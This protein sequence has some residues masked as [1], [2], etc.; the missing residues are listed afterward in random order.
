M[1][2]VRSI[3]DERGCRR[4]VFQ[5]TGRTVRLRVFATDEPLA[6]LLGQ[7]NRAY[8]VAFSPDGR[9]LAVQH[10]RVAAESTVEVRALR[11]NTRGYVKTVAGKPG[12][13]AFT[14]DGRVLVASSSATVVAWDARSGDQRLL[15]P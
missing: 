8:S 11:S 5:D 1:L 3:A 14:R 12:D 7:T 13:L 15:A 4:I 9:L 2:V 10:K 6:T